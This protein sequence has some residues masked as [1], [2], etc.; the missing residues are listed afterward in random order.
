MAS[1]KKKHNGIGRDKTY[2]VGSRRNIPLS[3]VVKEIEAGKHT[4]VHLYTYNGI[5][6]PRDNPDYLEKDNVNSTI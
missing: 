6:F 1:I 2:D 4:Q 3:V 5:K